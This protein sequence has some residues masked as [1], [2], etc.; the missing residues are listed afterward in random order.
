MIYTGLD[1]DINKTFFDK[2][3]TLGLKTKTKI[4]SSIFL[5]PR[6]FSQ[7]QGKTFHFIVVINVYKRFFF[8]IFH[9]KILF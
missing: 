2:T 4:E 7:D 3:K 9:R 6:L 1:S 5:R 8:F